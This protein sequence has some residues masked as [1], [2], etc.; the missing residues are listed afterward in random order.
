MTDLHTQNNRAVPTLSKEN[1]ERYDPL[2]Q[3]GIYAYN[4]QRPIGSQNTFCY[5]PFKSMYFGLEGKVYA[6]CFNQKHVMGT[7]PNNSIKDIWEGE[8]AN[9]LRDHILHNDLSLGCHV[10]KREFERKNYNYINASRYDTIPSNKKYPTKM[11]FQL[12]NTCNLECVMC[13]GELSSAI[14]KNRDKL[15][16]IHSAYDSSFADQLVE[17]IPHLSETTFSGGEPFLI[18]THYDIWDKIISINPACKIAVQTN[19]TI[20][21][22]RIKDIL[23]RGNFGLSISIDSLKRENYEKIRVNAKF[24]NISE[25]ILYFNHYCQEK[26]NYLGISFCPMRHNWEEIPDILNF[27]NELGALFYFSTVW[28]PV[29]DALW[30]LSSEKLNEIHSFLKSYT[31]PKSTSIE[32][33]NSK[34]YHDILL[35]IES[36]YHKALACEKEEIL[37]DEEGAKD[38]L[39]ERISTFIETEPDLKDIGRDSRLDEYMKKVESSLNGDTENMAYLKI[40]KLLNRIGIEPFMAELKSVSIEKL[41]VEIAKVVTAF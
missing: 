19:G 18:N 3:E 15:P 20:L 40:I 17:F 10:C 41:R 25:N 16:A 31:L 1:S 33:K 39:I 36:W 2:S 22:N 35:M 30:S 28:F 34:S 29:A 6:C 38:M 4:A 9:K 5:A 27:C 8:E 11:E 24:D 13:S 23:K 37:L 14:R 26:D 12:G 32:I 21:N 7:Y